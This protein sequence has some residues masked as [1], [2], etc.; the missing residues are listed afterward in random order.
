MLISLIKDKSGIVI[1]WTLLFIPVLLFAMG[2][3]LRQTEIVTG[4]DID[5]QGAVNSAV[6]GAAAQITD[7]SQAAGDPHICTAL[8]HIVFRQELARNLNLDDVT[9]KPCSDSLLKESPEYV[10]VVYNGTDIY[11]TSGALGGKIFT[12]SNNLLTS[13]EFLSSGF[14]YTFGLDNDAILLDGGGKIQVTL[15]SPG[16]IA[17]VKAKSVKIIGPQETPEIVRWGSARVVY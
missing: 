16:V 14:P 8:A 15:E 3:A 13:N 7:E 6:K 9:L 4:A 17:L 1:L 12:F 11:S 10:F 2:Y 5:L